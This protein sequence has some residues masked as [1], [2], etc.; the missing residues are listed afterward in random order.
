M[1][2]DF[3]KLHHETAKIKKW[4]KRNYLRQ[5]FHYHLYIFKICTFHRVQKK[6]TTQNNW[7]ILFLIK[8]IHY[9]EKFKEIRNDKNTLFISNY[10]KF[11]ILMLKIRFKMSIIYHSKMNDLTEKINQNFKQYF[12]YYVNKY[13]NNWVFLLFTSQ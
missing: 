6:Y 1:K 3:Y 8:F 9:H 7:N 11:L 13:Q 2:R 4:I 10:W 12:W 5:Y